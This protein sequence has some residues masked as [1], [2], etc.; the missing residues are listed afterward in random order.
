MMWNLK[1][2]TFLFI[3]WGL[4][5]AFAFD[6]KAGAEKIKTSVERAW[7]FATVFLTSVSFVLIWLLKGLLQ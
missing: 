6:P 5:V 7:L 3:V 1:L 4:I 2:F